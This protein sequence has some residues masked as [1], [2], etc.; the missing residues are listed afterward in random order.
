MRRP[1]KDRYLPDA[2]LS[3]FDLRRYSALATATPQQWAQ[4]IFDRVNLQI[5]AEHP[6]SQHKASELFDKLKADPLCELGFTYEWESLPCLD[7]PAIKLITVKRLQS[8]MDAVTDPSDQ[9]ESAAHEHERM[10]EGQPSLNITRTDFSDANNPNI[11]VDDLLLTS[12]SAFSGVFAHLAVDLRATDTQLIT[13][14][15]QWLRTWREQTDTKVTRGDYQA[16][17]RSWHNNRVLP[18][19]DLQLYARLQKHKVSREQLLKLLDLEDWDNTRNKMDQ[20]AKQANLIFNFD[21]FHA[22]KDFPS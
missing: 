19:F 8:L 12:Q 22:L 9:S 15:Q 11:A 18:Y 5:L 4:F 20:L 14:F 1:L 16:K 17:V 6:D 7:Q 13:N 3:W 10:T 21:T 2:N